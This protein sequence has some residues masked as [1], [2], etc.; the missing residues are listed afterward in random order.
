M[1]NLLLILTTIL[2]ASCT[3]TNKNDFD[4]QKIQ[5]NNSEI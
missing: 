5:E 1:K 3:T 4:L 2:A